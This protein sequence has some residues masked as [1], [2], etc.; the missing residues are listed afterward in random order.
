[1]SLVHPSERAFPA[2]VS[3]I[4]DHQYRKDFLTILDWVLEHNPDIKPEVKWNQPMFTHH[5]TFITGFSLA[6]H[7]CSMAPEVLSLVLDLVK[8]AG[9]THGAKL[10]R[11]PFDRPVRYDVIQAVI[12]MQMERKRLITTFWG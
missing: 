10:F 12:D 7:H 8:E 5:G 11:I 2:Y 4:K 3:R 6:S 1:M 9:Y